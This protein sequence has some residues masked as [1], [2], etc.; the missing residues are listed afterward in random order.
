MT[1]GSG[2]LRNKYAIVGVGE[3]EFSRN[4]GRTTRAMG[5]EAIKAAIDDSG[6]DYDT[7]SWG[8]SCYAVGDAANSESIASDVGI[9]LD[10]HAD[11]VGGGSSGET[12][13]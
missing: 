4:S 13:V 11:T 3:T 7:T 12:L 1:K 6:L 8:I 5:A 2:L 9:R 10:Y